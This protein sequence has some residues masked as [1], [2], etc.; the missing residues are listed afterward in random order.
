MSLFAELKRRNVFKVAAAYLII[1]WLIMQVGEVMAPALHLPDWI[2]SALAFFLIL[3]FPLALFF[4]WAFEMTPEGLK[5]EKDDD[6]SQSITTQ[7][8]QKLNRAVVS[9]LLLALGYFAV[10]K[11]LLDPRRDADMA[12]ALQKAAETA[13]AEA[14]EAEQGPDQHSIAVLPLADMSP[15]GDNE[16]FSDGLTE[17]LLNVLAK[18]HEL[19]VAGRTS[20]FA[21]KGRNEDLRE[22]AEKLNVRSILEGSVRKDDARNRV[23]ITLQL[24]NA[25]DGYHLWS[26]TYDR[27]L[28]DIFAIQEEVAREVANALRVELLGEDEKRLEQVASTGISAYEL[29]LQ[30]LQGIRIASYVSLGRAVDHLQQVLTL[31][32]TYLPARLALVQA[33][34]E[35]AGTGAITFEEAVTRGR[36][37][38]EAVLETQPNNAEAH[39][40]LAILHAY[41]DDRGAAEQE[42]IR[43]LELDPNNARALGE[44]GRFLFDNGE[45]GRGQVLL[46]AAL[47]IEPYA[48]RVLWDKCQTNAFLQRKEV[49]LAACARIAEVEPDSVFVDYGPA[50]VHLFSG[51]IARGLL[52]Y[53]RAIEHDPEDYEMLGAMTLFWSFLGD[54]DRAREWL[55]RAEAIGAGQP[56]PINARLLLYQFQERHDLARDLVREA[57]GRDM[58]DRHGTN[59]FFRHINAYESVQANDYEAGLQP[60]RQLLPWA[61]ARELEAPADIGS[62]LDDL[63]Y[64]ADLLMR[65]DPLSERPAELLRLV[66][67]LTDA[68]ATT[69]FLWTG[70]QRR[71][72]LAVLRGNEDSAIALLN[73]CFDKGFIAYWRQFM[74][75]DPIITRLQGRA[76]Y[77][78]LI[79]RYEAEMDRQRELAYELLGV[80]P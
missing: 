77:Q 36:P 35:M 51:D 45:K 31:D 29:Y 11:F 62:Y 42:F 1:G 72:Q 37:V 63:I 55:Q 43:A 27:D 78:Q 12:A 73:E 61:F 50:L 25:D 59:F 4:A 69:T 48:V 58:D 52:G 44:Y 28:D 13:Q 26:E 2:M 20:S 79:A 10:D 65:A 33:W 71:A 74:L 67:P 46:D 53:T 60:Y 40:H 21:F 19:R 15:A 57:L 75:Y 80:G 38:V 9:L 70:P 23:R 39:T 22:I 47:E 3:G 32:P 54:G 30:A 18:I 41:Q 7:T 56:V 76:A 49:A 64:I 66:E 24:I 5:K 16:Y 14:A 17:E 6:R 68:E 34:I 8:G